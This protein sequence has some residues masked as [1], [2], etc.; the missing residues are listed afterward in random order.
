MDYSEQLKERIQKTIS[1]D[2]LEHSPDHV[3]MTL[4]NLLDEITNMV[5]GHIGHERVTEDVVITSSEI[6]SLVRI[7]NV[8]GEFMDEYHNFLTNKIQSND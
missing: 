1:L 7:R 5:F 4:E 3:R 2:P 6:N 8:Y